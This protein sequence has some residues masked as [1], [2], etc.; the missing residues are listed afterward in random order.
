MRPPILIF[1]LHLALASPG[2]QGLSSN[3]ALFWAPKKARMRQPILI[4]SPLFATP[5]IVRVTTHLL[6]P[7]KAGVRQ[8]ILIFSP[9]LALGTPRMQ[10]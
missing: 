1:Y 6:A 3:S 2:I 9:H 4:L 8:P 7:E 10:G 5:E